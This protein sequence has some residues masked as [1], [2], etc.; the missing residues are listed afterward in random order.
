MR[1]T[2]TAVACLAVLSLGAAQAESL[3]ANPA[4]GGF[5]DQLTSLNSYVHSTYQNAGLIGLIQAGKNALWEEANEWR[6]STTFDN[7]EFLIGFY[8][9]ACLVAV[10]FILPDYSPLFNMFGFVYGFSWTES[11]MIL[12]TIASKVN[13]EIW[14]MIEGPVYAPLEINEFFSRFEILLDLIYL[15][16]TL[17]FGKW[18]LFGVSLVDTARNF[19]LL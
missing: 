17:Y 3:P 11:N 15:P 7:Q 2:I 9:Q 1:K 19:M 8:A 6:A 4:Q 14:H 12:V 5:L 18:Y 16:T 10:S 13:T